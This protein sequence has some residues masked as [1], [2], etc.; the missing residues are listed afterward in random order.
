MTT[1]TMTVHK[2]LCELKLL[3]KRITKEINDCK[4]CVANKANNKKI[5]GKTINEYEESVKEEYQSIA[6]LMKRY[7][8]INAAV[9]QSNAETK[10]MDGK[11][12]VAEAMAIKNKL[13]PLKNNLVSQMALVF[14]SEDYKVTSGNEALER[15]ADRI[16]TNSSAGKTDVKN[17]GEEMMS[18]REQYIEKQKLELIDPL[19]IQD[20]MKRMRDEIDD[21]LSDIDSELSI[22]NATTKIVVNY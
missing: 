19:G 9:A 4:F 7:A 17:L 5:G 16:V 18:L 2:A 14:T 1:E 15:E 20:E 21:F 8:A 6:D 10:I 11:Y 13:I 22:S 12:T 3:N